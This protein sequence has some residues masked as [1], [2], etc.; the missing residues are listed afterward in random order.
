MPY[1]GKL[2]KLLVQHDNSG[3]NPAWHLFKVDVTCAKDKQV[4]DGRPG[5]EPVQAC[6]CHVHWMGCHAAGWVWQTVQAVN[7]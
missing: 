2:Q 6:T 5:A 3:A 1:L 4:G 7:H